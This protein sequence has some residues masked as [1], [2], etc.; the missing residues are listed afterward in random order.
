MLFVILEYVVMATAVTGVLL[1]NHKLIACFP[2]WLL[3]NS[4]SG[5]VHLNA[6][7]S[8][9]VLRDVA[10]LILAVHG[11]RCWRGKGNEG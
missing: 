1:N 6:G 4:I 11:W 7:M 5:C 8:G 10:F 3:S 2:V 9:M